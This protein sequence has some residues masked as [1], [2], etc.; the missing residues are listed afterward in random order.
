MRLHSLL[1]LI[2]SSVSLMACSNNEEVE[3]NAWMAQVKK[4][5]PVRVQPLA[6]PKVFVPVAF[7]G[8]DLSDPFDPMKLSV[9]FARLKAQNDNG[10]KPDFDRPREVLEAFSLEEMKMV[11]TFDNR[12]NLIGLVEVGK[13]IYQARVGNFIGQNYGKI[14][15]V[16][17][18]RIDFVEVVQ[19]TNGEWTERKT[20]LELQEAK[21]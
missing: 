13:L 9:V 15:S 21:K 18:E 20:S 6:A 11:G 12:K 14:S 5:T 19:D 4:E 3:L 8:G 17:Q 10:L 16:S 2:V 1:L 7:Q